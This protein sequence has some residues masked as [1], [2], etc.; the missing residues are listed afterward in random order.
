MDIYK[1]TK[2]CLKILTNYV[3]K[4]TIIAFDELNCDYGKVCDQCIKRSF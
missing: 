3:T 1:P 4:G 2:D